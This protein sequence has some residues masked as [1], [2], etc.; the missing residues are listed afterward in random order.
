MTTPYTIRQG[1]VVLIRVATLPTDRTPV[2]LSNGRIVLAFGEAT[3]HAHVIGISP[4]AAT[5]IAEA[6]IARA[7]LWSTPGGARYLEVRAPVVLRHEE[8]SP[9]T[10]PPGIYQLPKQVEY[11]APQIMRRVED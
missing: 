2:P 5:E 3:G 8:H 4:E 9:L 1:D 6:A 10:I 11:V 7:R